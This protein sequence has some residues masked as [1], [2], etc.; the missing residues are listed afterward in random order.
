MGGRGS[1]HTHTVEYRTDPALLQ[2]I[3]ELQKIAREN[4]VRSKELEVSLRLEIENAKRFENEMEQ[5]KTQLYSISDPEQYAEM[6]KKCFNQFLEK[7]DPSLFQQ[8]LNDLDSKIHIG[9]FGVISCGKSQLIN[10]LFNE[11]D[12][13]EVGAGETTQSITRVGDINAS[14]T[15]W[16]LPGNSVKFDFLVFEQLA[17]LKSLSKV[18]ICVNSSLN[19]PFYDSILKICYRLQQRVLIAITKIDIVEENE[20][21]GLKNQ[22]M[23]ELNNVYGEAP[24]FCVSAKKFLAGEHN[25]AEWNELI[26]ELSNE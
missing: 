26:N 16:D 25:Y 4:E 15:L 2:Q 1:S 5:L 8:K 3:Q 14:I 7:L 10:A 11:R 24:V 6:Q 22:I 12:K 17:F 21:D 19:D 23:S 20:R 9:M 13:C 18:C